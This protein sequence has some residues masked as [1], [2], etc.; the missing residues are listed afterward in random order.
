MN[1][2]KDAP[3]LAASP[4][5]F[6][7]GRGLSCVLAGAQPGAN[8]AAVARRITQATGLKAYTKHEF[9]WETIWWPAASL[10]IRKIRSL[11]PAVV[12]RG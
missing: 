2:S 11:E 12:F 9:F 5:S 7:M 1:V 8:P 4:S 10:G 3:E 6:V